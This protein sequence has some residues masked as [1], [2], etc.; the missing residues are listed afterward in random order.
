MP[1]PA[2]CQ[3]VF[4]EARKNGFYFLTCL[5]LNEIFLLIGSQLLK[6]RNSAYA[7]FATREAMI[8][9]GWL[10]GAGNFGLNAICRFI[11]Y[12]AQQDE[13]RDDVSPDHLSEMTLSHAECL[14]YTLLHSTGFPLFGAGAARLMKF[15]KPLRA[16]VAIAAGMALTLGAV[17]CLLCVLIAVCFG[18]ERCGRYTDSSVASSVNDPY[19]V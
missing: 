1:S 9:V 6:N 12:C 19:Q 16:A 13:R 17:S 14:R 4:S 5:F 3:T 15:N 7:D 8:R 2:A 10:S 18:W 11:F